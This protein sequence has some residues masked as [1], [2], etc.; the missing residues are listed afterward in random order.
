MRGPYRTV[1]ALPHATALIAW[2]LVARLPLGMTPLALMLL[3]RGHGASYGAA[4]AVAAAYGGALALGAPVAGRLVDRRGPARVLR[5][6][7]VVHPLFL[8]L[9]VVLAVVDAPVAALGAAAAAAGATLPPIAPTVRTVLPALAG[10]ELRSTVYALEAALQELFWF[11]GPLLVA[12]LVLLDPVAGVAGAA[13]AAAIGTVLLARLPPVREAAAAGQEGASLLGAL[14]AP[15]VRLLIAFATTLGLGFGSVEVGMPAFAELHGTRALGGLGLAA[16]SAGSFVGG[17]LAG[18]RPTD[19][20]DRRLLR[21]APLIPLALLAIAG[22]WSIPSL[23]VLAFVAG[24]PVAPGVAAVYGLID[25]VAP[26]PAIA[27]A[28]AWFGMA[29]SLGLALGT[30]A[31]GSLVDHVG[32]RAPFVLGPALAASGVALLVWRRE[33]LTVSARP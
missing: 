13:V 4:G 10:G 21:V 20:V 16:F 6:R 15:G 18:T 24:L 26:R 8:A 28:F 9:V 11:G 23:C 17:L 29:I 22:A 30:A 31:S 1:F 32:V 12:V 3:V 27:E 19:D 25:R 2:S 14:E 33:A 5:R 7:A